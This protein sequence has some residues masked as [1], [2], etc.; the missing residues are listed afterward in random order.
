MILH[1][2]FLKDL[3]MDI[4]ACIVLPAALARYWGLPSSRPSSSAIIRNYQNIWS[5]W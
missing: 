4:G 1:I 3:D 2:V 5:A